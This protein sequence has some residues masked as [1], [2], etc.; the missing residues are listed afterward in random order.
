MPVQAGCC[1]HGASERLRRP[2]AAE[3]RGG[4]RI[5]DDFVFVVVSLATLFVVFVSIWAL[6]KV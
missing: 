2:A 1:H 3:G 6:E 5:M 4:N